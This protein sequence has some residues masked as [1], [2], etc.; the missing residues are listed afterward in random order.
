VHLAVP[1]VGCGDV[2]VLLVGPREHDGIVEGVGPMERNVGL[3]QIDKARRVH[4]HKLHLGEVRIA[5]GK[6]DELVGVVLDR[7]HAVEQHD[8]PEWAIC[9]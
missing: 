7:A 6:G 3:Q 8:F 2:L 9:H 1:V 4:L 5:A